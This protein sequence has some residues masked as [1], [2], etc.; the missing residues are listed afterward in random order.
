MAKVMV[1]GIDLA[2]LLSHCQ[3]PSTRAEAEKRLEVLQTSHP[4]ELF[5]GLAMILSSDEIQPVAR[6]LAGLIL[7]NS[8][9]GAKDGIRDKQC[10]E[11]WIAL[12]QAGEP[13]KII[14]QGIVSTLRSSRDIVA[15]RTAA[16]VI[17]AIAA[18]ELPLGQWADLIDPILISSLSSGDV[19]TRSSVLICLAYLSEELSS[20]ELDVSQSMI[21]A[22]LTAIVQGMKDADDSV[23]KEATKALYYVIVLAKSNF[24]NEPERDVIVQVVCDTIRV[25]TVS[26]PQLCASACECLVQMATCYYQYL[27]KYMNA[28]GPLS[29]ELMKSSSEELCMCA[30]EFWSTICDE[31]NYIAECIQFGDKPSSDSFHLG[32]QAMSYLVPILV[33]TMSKRSSAEDDE[34][35]DEWNS[36]M[37]AGTCLS[38]LAQSIGDDIVDMVI[39]FVNANYN[40]PNANLREASMLAYGSIMDGPTEARLLPIVQMS[41]PVIVDALNDAKSSAVRDNAA[42]AIGRI[43]QFHVLSIVPALPNLVPILLGKLQS[44]KPRVAANIAWAFDILGQE[45]QSR[46][47]PLINAAYFTQIVGGLLNACVRGDSNVGNLRMTCYAAVSSLASSVGMK[48]D[49]SSAEPLVAL[50]DEMCNRLESSMSGY[51]AVFAGK[52]APEELRNAISSLSQSDRDCELQGHICG[53]MLVVTNRLKTVVVSSSSLVEV[54]SVRAERIFKLYMHVFQLYQHLQQNNCAIHEEALLATASLASGMG[55]KFGHFMPNFFPIVLLGL[56]N[57]ESFSV[58]S[59]SIGIVGDLSRAL[60][61]E[62]TPYCDKLVREAFAP[63]LERKEVDRRLKPLVMT[64]VGDLALACRGNFEPFVAGTIK[65]LSQASTTRLE[66]GPVDSEDW[67]DY[68]NQLRSSVLD[69]YTGLVHGLCEAKKQVILKDHVQ[70]ILEFI[71]RLIEDKSV[72][73]DVI[74]AAMG[75]VGDLVISFQADLARLIK[76]APFMQRLVSYSATSKD[77]GIQETG[78]WLARTVDKYH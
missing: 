65:L 27:S 76:D 66:D 18:I 34:E 47:I 46:E 53:C 17:S 64:S 7:K 59:M 15:R 63:L 33:E 11:R 24:A 49:P 41:L 39:K 74:K 38:L 56:S 77:T 13:G 26:S 28:I 69:A 16:Q 29:F 2:D 4:Y 12:S 44:D 78:Q 73:E 71:V 23:K 54:L 60:D 67:I 22:M 21:N 5:P 45:Q 55:K 20:R 75:L 68:L 35:E 9:A 3:N 62:I 51:A 6:Q 10:K 72:S 25:S 61:S 1:N 57:V 31:E 37:A 70:S 52:M 40:S 30:I 48:E 32:K 43:C 50:L 19:I 42:W 58:C 36:S 14:K 8:F